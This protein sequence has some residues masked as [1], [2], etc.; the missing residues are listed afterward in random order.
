MQR[1]EAL[2]TPELISGAAACGGLLLPDLGKLSGGRARRKIL[3]YF[4][5]PL[6]LAEL[7]EVAGAFEA[8]DTKGDLENEAALLPLSTE[9]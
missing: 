3:R 8:F 1:Y 7:T 6:V 9:Q 2:K 4:W 5:P